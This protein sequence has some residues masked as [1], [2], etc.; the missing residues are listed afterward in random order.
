MK[1]LGSAIFA[2]AV[3]LMLGTS[4]QAQD[5]HW[6]QFNSIPLLQNPANTGLF[7][8]C[9]RFTGIYRSQWHSILKFES[10]PLFRTYSGSFDM[11]INNGVSKHDAW[12]VGLA[13]LADK[14]G[15][16][17]FGTTGGLVSFSYMKA[18]NQK[19]NHYLSIGFAGGL[20]QR[21]INFARLKWGN[22]FDGDGYNPDIL[23]N[24]NIT[25]DNFIYFDI[26]AGAMW[27]YVKDKRTNFYAGFSTYH[28]NQPNQSF[29]N[30]ESVPLY[31]RWTFN[32]GVQ[33][34][35]GGQVDLV[36]AIL[37]MKQGPATETS[38]GSYL[39]FFFEQ[40]NPLGNAFY[41]GPWYRIVGDMNKAL[42]SESL[43]LASRID[44]ESFT[45]GMSYDL[46]FSELTRATNGRG[47]FEVF[48]TYIIKCRDR[49]PDVKFCP[50]F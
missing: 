37:F 21:S 44:Y 6:S 18:L 41:I 11:R 40:R 15:E 35:L 22:Q 13:F 32:A 25:S 36:P 7:N 30:I 50:R 29:Y 10:I 12:G 46:N 42:T 20:A 8:G 34:G 28:L 19:G 43:I 33:V 4:T 9:Y 31:L 26:S 48:L 2:L 38:I 39:K 14:A 27:Y 49:R 24:E 47:A 16:S 23:S 1:K 5:P 45:L 3:L 17:E